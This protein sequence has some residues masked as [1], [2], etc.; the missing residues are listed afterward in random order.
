M[1]HEQLQKNFLQANARP[2]VCQCRSD[3][4]DF[5]RGGGRG[6]GRRGGGRFSSRGDR[7][8]FGEERAFD[9]SRG[10]SGFS[11]GRGGRGFD[12]GR[13]FDGGRGEGR[14]FKSG[15]G[16][17]RTSRGGFSPRGGTSSRGRFRDGGP[18][19]GGRFQ[20]RD[21]FIQFD[22]RRGGQRES[23]GFSPQAPQGDNRF[24]GAARGRGRSAPQNPSEGRDARESYE[25]RQ[26]FQSQVSTG[27]LCSGLPSSCISVCRYRLGVNHATWQRPLSRKI[28]RSLWVVSSGLSIQVPCFA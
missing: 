17:G 28:L 4:D 14:G 10:R 7:S 25:Q 19:S 2:C 15:R 23:E 20:G 21:D 13:G 22:D 12:N 26:P 3:S 6:G 1:P 27:I 8:S 18:P 11:R 24:N 16:G 5:S 9:G